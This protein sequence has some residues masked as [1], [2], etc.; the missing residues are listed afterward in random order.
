QVAD[1]LVQTALRAGTRD[2]VT[3][4]VV[5]VVPSGDGTTRPQVVGAASERRGTQVLSPPPTPAEKA[6][7]LSREASGRP[8][9]PETPLL[10]EEQARPWVRALR[11]A[12]VTLAVLAVL[13]A[14]GWAG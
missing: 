9:P 1:G 3:V 8:E 7:Q 14:G 10:A 6:A 13:A 5:D 11:A 12:V 4:V 2:N